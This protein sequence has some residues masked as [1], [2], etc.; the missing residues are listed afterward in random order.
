VN[1]I[2]FFLSFLLFI[3]GCSFNKNSKFWTKSEKISDENNVNFEVIFPKEEALK[4][5][6]NSNLKVNLNSKTFEKTFI[7]NFQNNNGRLK[8]NGS[9]KKS[10]R[11]RFSK[12]KDFYSYQPEISFFK[13]N[14][15]FFDNKGTILQFNEKSKLI[16]KKNF[17]SK[18][19]KKLNPILQLV[20][21]GKHLVVADNIAKYYLLDVETGELVWS[22]NNLAPFNSQI[23]IFKDKFF[24]IDFSNTLRCFSI[25]NGN[26]LWNVKTENSLIR[27][28]KKLS[29]VIIDEKIY[30]NNSTGDISAVDANSGKLLWQL[31]TQSSLIY[32]SA[33]SLETSD[34]VSDGKNLFFSNNKNQIFSVD[35]KSGSFNWENKINSN[36]RTTI[37][38]N[39]LF[40]VSLE[41]Y[42]IITEKN[43]GNIIRVTDIFK[44][45]SSKKRNEIKP[46]G[47]IIGLNK[48][49]ISTNKG[50]L[51]VAD[52]K[53]GELITTLKIDNEKISKPF[54]SNNNLFIIKDN[55]II[56][57][58]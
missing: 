28:K 39:Y 49:Y 23:K 42:L 29:M 22:K 32:E 4:K 50:R 20:N 46:T 14:V 34:I 55:A 41:G 33:F 45:F 37:I 58:D 25:K 56:K 36:L 30:F 53:S 1:R 17:Y 40:S 7:N 18:S 48:I 47:F 44:N 9:L 52:I 12:I 27:S 54:V 2:L 8:F 3:F 5:E 26:E 38:D 43:S 24:I 35:I 31:P 13:K 51:V 6:F 15:I 19:E 21:N 10:S 57:L 11:Y 16:W